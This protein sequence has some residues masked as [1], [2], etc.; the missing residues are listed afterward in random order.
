[1]HQINITNPLPVAGRFKFKVVSGSIKF[2]GAKI[3]PETEIDC[4]Y[5]L[6]VSAIPVIVPLEEN[7]SI[8]II[9]GECLHGQSI[10]ITHPV[11]SEIDFITPHS[12]KILIMG[13]KST[14]KSTMVRHYVNHLL[15]SNSVSHAGLVVLDIDVGQPEYSLPG[16]ISAVLIKKPIF[17]LPH[18]MAGDFQVIN[19]QYYGH[20]S[21]AVDVCHFMHC[22]D[23]L[24]ANIDQQYQ[25]IPWIINC[26]GYSNSIGELTINHIMDVC[27][28]TEII[29]IKKDDMEISRSVN[30]SGITT[31]SVPSK[32]TNSMISPGD[33][34]W[35]RIACLFRPSMK[36]DC[37]WMAMKD[38]DFYTETETV[39]LE[40]S[41]RGIEI[42][43]D[44]RDPEMNKD[45]IFTRE[46]LT[47]SFIAM[48]GID[49]S[50]IG[51]GMVQAV[52]E[53][54]DVY[55]MVPRNS[56]VRSYLEGVKFIKK[57]S[58]SFSCRDSAYFEVAGTKIREGVRD[59]EFWL[60]DV[61]YD[62]QSGSKTAQNRTNLKRTR[63]T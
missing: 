63:Y 3:F 53:D 1:M 37:T 23:K 36:Q 16:T 51:Y 12:N 17:N 49:Q 5:P 7:S 46:V 50:I 38:V 42:I 25:S 11:I 48:L 27:G 9:S 8:E 34:R 39:C 56:E 60:S 6:F 20:L 31:Y 61:L 19:S 55:V 59:E 13:E 52:S 32:K 44:C 21:P 41:E 4:C 22:I 40:M 35:L 10:P 62:L 24:I 28:I 29:H 45:P 15:T 54:G 47:G 2:L 57:G 30:E 58:V 18:S 26:H 33:L 43:T 14:G